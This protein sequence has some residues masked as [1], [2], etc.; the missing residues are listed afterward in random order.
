MKTI[1]YL[2]ILTLSLSVCGVLQAQESKKGLKPGDWFEC[3]MEF[4]NWMPVFRNH[5]YNQ[6]RSVNEQ[7]LVSIRFTLENRDAANVEKWHYK[8]LRYRTVLPGVSNVYCN[9][10]W[11]PGYFRENYDSIRNSLTG[12]LS[13][14]RNSIVKHDFSYNTNKYFG[15][16]S[17][18]PC[19]SDNNSFHSSTFSTSANMLA[20]TVGKIGDLIFETQSFKENNETRMD[21]QWV[22]GVKYI[23][24]KELNF[25]LHQNSSNPDH[26]KVACTA[27]LLDNGLTYAFTDKHHHKV[28]AITN[29]SFPLPN[30]AVLNVT[31][32]RKNKEKKENQF[33]DLIWITPNNPAHVINETGEPQYMKL[34][35]SNE[36][37]TFTLKCG[38]A[39]RLRTGTGQVANLFI[40]PG[41]TIDVV[42]RD[43]GDNPLEIIGNSNSSWWQSNGSWLPR[44][45]EYTVDVHNLAQAPISEEFRSYFLLANEIHK[46]HSK[47]ISTDVNSFKNS[48]LDFFYLKSYHYNTLGANF[49]SFVSNYISYKE[50]AINQSG[51]P[52][53]TGFRYNIYKAITHHNDFMLYFELY[54]ILTGQYSYYQMGKD[55][56]KFT[57]FI[58]QCGDTLLR[59]NLRNKLL[60][61]QSVQPGCKLPFESLLTENNESVNLTPSKGKY[62]L[63]FLCSAPDKLNEFRKLTDSLPDHI[64][65]ISYC[66]NLEMFKYSKN[67]LPSLTL[68]DEGNIE[69][70]GHPTMSPMFDD[71]L[72]TLYNY[73][74]ILYDDKGKILYSNTFEAQY[75]ESN[76]LEHYR[77]QIVSAIEK[78][79]VTSKSDL[80]QLLLIIGISVLFS[81]FFTFIF[82]RYRIGRIKKRSAQE[83]MIQKLKLKSVQSQLNPH[84][85]FNALN[86][87]QLL[88]NSNN[89][90]QANK[91]LV[92]FSN[93]LRGVLGNADK[94]LIP[95]TDELDLINRYCELEQLRMDFAY[96]QAVNTDT[97]PDLIEVPYMLLQPIVENAIKHGVGKQEGKGQLRL[98]VSEEDTFLTIRALDN[99]PGF[100]GFSIEQLLEKGKGLKLTMEKLDSIYEDDAELTFSNNALT[101]GAVVNIKL[102]I[103]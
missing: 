64:Q 69:L 102:K 100:N 50:R 95:L 26:R 66:L 6:N 54:Q 75:G 59:K 53:R 76:Y 96:E 94:R 15:Q 98:E 3:E 4:E 35:S 28:L 31:D 38:V 40:E 72:V 86:S 92:G 27:Y 80:S 17:V 8:V 33:T 45:G 97:P 62:G 39:F 65:S 87:I 68:A 44:V 48:F 67:Q 34:T 88:V 58:E 91:Y 21:L 77:T 103:G 1:F 84:F 56:Q 79:K 11:Y 63:L 46:R 90:R 13:V 70:Y 25:I 20:H 51:S 101:P 57:E 9:D 78:S 73:M 37:K 42:L 32:Q 5:Y 14:Q 36:S 85:M 2:L 16:T 71:V 52:F 82:Y 60:G 83:K 49:K 99:G 89:V 10:T 23:S 7:H 30:K 41:D 81:V 12:I 29:A 18:L 19:K 22:D 74:I 93:L 43:D 61:R 24:D 55:E 47:M